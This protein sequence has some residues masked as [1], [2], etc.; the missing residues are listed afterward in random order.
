MALGAILGFG[1]LLK[2]ILMCSIHHNNIQTE[3]ASTLHVSCSRLLQ[4]SFCI[5][6][7]SSLYIF[8]YMKTVEEYNIVDFQQP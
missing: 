7:T 1:A 2:D 6:I 4:G 5:V 3:P 8:I